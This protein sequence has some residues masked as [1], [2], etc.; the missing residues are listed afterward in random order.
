MDAELTVSSVV[1]QIYDPIR[2]STVSKY[3]HDYDVTDAR[4][5]KGS[6]IT[7]RIGPPRRCVHCRTV[8]TEEIL[9]QRGKQMVVVDFDRLGVLIEDHLAMPPEE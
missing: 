4:R 5:A 6:R 9:V 8:R 7:L 1:R 2:N 3:R